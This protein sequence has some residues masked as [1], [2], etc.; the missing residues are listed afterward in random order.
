MSPAEIRR[1]ALLAAASV[2]VSLS[3]LDCGA[4]AEP[5]AASG[6]S[7]DARSQK[8]YTLAD[9]EHCRPSIDEVRA[10]SSR[11][12]SAA[13]E[14]SQPSWPPTLTPGQRDCCTL[15]VDALGQG[16]SGPRTEDARAIEQAF[17]T[18]AWSCC[19]YLQDTDKRWP[20]RLFCSPWGPPMPPA[21]PPGLAAEALA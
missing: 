21:M 2:T 11:D 17:S 16:R 3:A 13:A 10:L 20:G 5:A 15:V 6:P 7:R 9:L 19:P 14:P 1:R 12:P 8:S 18:P 4:P